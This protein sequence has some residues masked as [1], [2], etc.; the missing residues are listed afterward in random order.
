MKPLLAVLLF[1]TS[2]FAA[3]SPAA[4]RV[5]VTAGLVELRATEAPVSAVLDQLARET[6]MT[7][8][9]DGPRPRNVVTLTLH[10]LTSTQAV[11]KVVEGLDL[12]YAIQVEGTA[13]PKVVVITTKADRSPSAAPESIAPEPEV[14]T[15]TEPAPGSLEEA[16][17]VMSESGT[18][19]SAVS[20]V[21]AVSEMSEPGA[22]PAMNSAGTPNQSLSEPPRPGRKGTAPV[23]D[24][25]PLPPRPADLPTSPFVPY[26]G[27]LNPKSAEAAAQA[28]PNTP[29]A[30]VPGEVVEMDGMDPNGTP[31]RQLKEKVPPPPN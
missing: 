13:P 4:I 3:Q 26:A 6:G 8:V 11:A 30:P 12:R 29:P 5:K 24:H 18:A 1:S 21:P 22:D 9:Y 10:G 2:A 31:T 28:S 14:E 23:A 15:E 25:P 7:V 16:V 19:E 17:E 20:A 27:A